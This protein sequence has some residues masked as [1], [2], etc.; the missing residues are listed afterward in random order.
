MNVKLCKMKCARCDFEW[1][2]LQAGYGQKSQHGC[3]VCHSLY[4]QEDGKPD[5]KDLAWVKDKKND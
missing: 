4:W 1:E 5:A 3:P 2:D